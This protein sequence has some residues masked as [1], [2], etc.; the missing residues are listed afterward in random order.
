MEWYEA[1]VRFLEARRAEFPPPEGAIVFYGSSSVRLWGTLADD[2]PDL[3]VVNLGFGGSTLAACA[4]FYGRLVGP[5]EPHALLIY[6]GDND[7]GDGRSPEE[8]LGSYHAL[9]AAVEYHHGGLRLGFLSLKPSPAR[10]HLVERFRAANAL[11]RSQVEARPGGFW[12]DVF[13]PML[14]ANGRPRQELYAADGLHLSA[15]GYHLWAELVSRQRPH[16][17]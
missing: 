6:A 17:S 16:F 14:G 10:W 9:N 8:V 2:F 11:L 15:A 13:E 1:E 7:L 3:P 4:H 5:L 12:I